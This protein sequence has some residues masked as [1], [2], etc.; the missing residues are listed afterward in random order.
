M[1]HKPALDARCG[2]AKTRL[3]S[4]VETHE[5][6]TRRPAR[7]PGDDFMAASNMDKWSNL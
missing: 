6:S 2:R 7:M 4:T 3:A 1:A 5:D